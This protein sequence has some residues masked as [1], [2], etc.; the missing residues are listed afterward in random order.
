MSSTESPTTADSAEGLSLPSS[1]AVAVIVSIAGVGT[2]LVLLVL[3]IVMAMRRY[4]YIKRRRS[5]GIISEHFGRNSMRASQRSQRISRLVAEASEGPSTTNTFNI[6]TQLLPEATK[7]SPFPPPPDNTFPSSAPVE[8]ELEKK[9]LDLSFLNTSTMDTT[10]PRQ[11]PSSD[12]L[13]LDKLGEGEYGPIYRGDAYN[14]EQD[15]QSR[16][17][18]VKMLAQQYTSGDRTMFNNDI[19]MLTSIVHINVVTLLAMCTDDSPECILLDAGLPGDLLTFIRD[20]KQEVSPLGPTVQETYNILKIADEISIGMSYLASERF[21]H[22]DLSLRNCIIGYSGV[23]KIAHFGLGP[24]LYPEAYY[25]VHDIDL[26]IRWMSPEA[27]TSSQFTSASDVWAFGVV[28][29]ELF[30]YGELPFDEKSNEEVISYVVREFG[31]LKCPHRCSAEIFEIPQSCWATDPK[32]RPNFA[33]LHDQI[34]RMTGQTDV[35]GSVSTFGSSP[36][37]VLESGMR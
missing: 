15:N 10:A 19:E 26:P 33:Y 36:I 29:F 5:R 24:V 1:E 20:K 7:T 34:F 6:N 31:K 2:I 37:P 8:I 27:I 16:P 3:I 18:T 23:V 25:R 17:V 14:L 9:D 12:L 35:S 32:L 30:S 21:V 13:L 28:L 11:F 4:S 22:K